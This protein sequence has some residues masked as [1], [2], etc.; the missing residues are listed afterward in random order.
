MSLFF[1]TVYVDNFLKCKLEKLSKIDV[2]KY[3][4]KETEKNKNK[5]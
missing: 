5:K 2:L 4:C 1:L 3:L